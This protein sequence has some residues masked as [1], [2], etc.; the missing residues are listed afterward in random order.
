[1]RRHIAIALLFVA[2]AATTVGAETPSLAFQPVEK[3]YSAFDTGLFRGKMRVDGEAQGLCS[4]V[5]VPTGM[6]LVAPP[7]MLSYY[8]LFSTGARYGKAV[9][10]WPVVARVVDDGALEIHFPPTAEHPMDLTGTFHWRS[11]DTLDLVTTVKAADALPRL[12][13]FLSSYFVDGFDALVYVNRNLY[14]EGPP[15]AMLRADGSELLDGNYLMFPRDQEALHM[16]YDGRWNIPPDPVTFAFVRYLA[17]PIAVRRNEKVGLTAVLMS[18]PEDCFAVAAPYN[19]QPPDNVAAHRSLYLSLFGRDLAAGQVAQS[20]CRLI[21]GKDLSDEA[22]L[23][24]YRQYLT[25]TLPKP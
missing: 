14:G 11:A 17:A 10:D 13:V 21:L 6:E 12:E 9:R 20:R 5:H 7:G 23:E 19:K 25:T 3:G 22:I 18:P 24:R 15:A 16:I 2:W 1:M 8:R 4:M